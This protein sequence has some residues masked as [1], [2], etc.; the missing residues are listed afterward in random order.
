MVQYSVHRTVHHTPY[1][2]QN[3]VRRDGRLLPLEAGVPHPLPNCYPS[4]SLSFHLNTFSPHRHLPFPGAIIVHAIFA[5]VCRR[6]GFLG[7]SVGSVAASRWSH[8]TSSANSA[9]WARR[10]LSSAARLD[11]K[12]NNQTPHSRGSLDESWQTGHCSVLIPISTSGRRRDVL[13]QKHMLARIGHCQTLET[14]AVTDHTPQCLS[15]FSS[16]YR[17]RNLP[18]RRKLSKDEYL[19]LFTA[20]DEPSEPCFCAPLQPSSRQTQSQVSPS[21]S[22]VVPPTGTE[23]RRE[24][25]RRRELARPAFLAQAFC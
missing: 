2:I 10:R 12:R 24:Q 9:C 5:P 18:G 23:T 8:P 11:G 20:D 4:R 22:T 19:M 1:T 21:H 13:A 6:H 14:I 7:R 15:P 3:A 25:E 17:R 16:A